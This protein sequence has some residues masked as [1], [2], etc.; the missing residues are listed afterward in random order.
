MKPVTLI[1]MS[2]NET[3]GRFRI[4]QHFSDIKNGLKQ[5]DALAL[6]VFIFALEYAIKKVQA[7]QEVLKFCN[8]RQFMVYADGDNLLGESTQ[9]IKEN[10]ENLLVSGKKIALEVSAEKIKC[11]CSM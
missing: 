9:T 4:D 11:L 6:L 8:T 2:L 5:A 3:H 10:A 7:N 1:K